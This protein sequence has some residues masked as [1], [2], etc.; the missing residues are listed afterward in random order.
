MRQCILI[1]LVLVIYSFSQN[2]NITTP[3]YKGDRKPF[4]TFAIAKYNR[5]IKNFEKEQEFFFNELIT[6]LKDVTSDEKCGI[7]AIDHELVPKV[8]PL[9]LSKK[10]EFR[11]YLPDTTTI[12]VDEHCPEV[13]LFIKQLSFKDLERERK[14]SIVKPG[15]AGKITTQD[16]I[17][18]SMYYVFWHNL[19]HKVISYGKINGKEASLVTRSGFNNT[20]GVEKTLRAT[21]KKIIN[22][23]PY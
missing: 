23:M 20:K 4:L 15:S 9:V 10:E 16:Y 19:D 8:T 12:C 2:V 6:R 17:K 22:N 3:E 18:P 7:I 1:V 11:I 21:A 14:S 5:T 13:I